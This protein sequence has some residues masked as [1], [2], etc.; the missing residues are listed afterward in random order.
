MSNLQDETITFTRAL[1][2]EL[3]GDIIKFKMPNQSCVDKEGK[4]P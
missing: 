2:H 4:K 3:A 1:M